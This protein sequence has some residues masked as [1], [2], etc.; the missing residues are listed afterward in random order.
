MPEHFHLLIS[1]PEQGNPSTVMQ[2]L[3]QR[4]A[5]R[6]MRMAQHSYLCA[7][8]DRVWQRRFYDFVVWNPHKRAEKLNYIRQNP[9]RRGLVRDPEQWSWSS[10]RHYVLKKPDQCW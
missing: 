1:E 4:F 6:I 8:P 7:Q 5:R 9:V 3:K 10:C 2:V